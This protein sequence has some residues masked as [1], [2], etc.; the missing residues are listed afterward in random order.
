M[1]ER[2][3]RA[4]GVN[5]KDLPPVIDCSRNVMNNW[6]YYGRIPLEQLD[7]CREQTGANMDWLM[8]GDQTQDKD[9]LP[10]EQ[11]KT[12]VGVLFDHSLALELITADSPDAIT[13]LT[14][15]IGKDIIA[16][17]NLTPLDKD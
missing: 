9:N 13:H 10:L 7:M 17:F 4:Y 3:A 14:N 8:Y 16:N 15:K 12:I 6:V 5:K 11:L 2:M 1:I